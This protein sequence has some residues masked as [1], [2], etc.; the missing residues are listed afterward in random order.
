M[1]VA[2]V[3]FLTH[4]IQTSAVT[5]IA[6]RSTLLA[7]I[8][9]LSALLAYIHYRLNHK[10]S[11]YLLSLGVALLGVFCKPIII[12][13]PFVIILYEVYFLR[14]KAERL[15]IGAIVPYFLIV[16]IVPILLMLL[17]FRTIDVSL[18]AFVTKE[19]DTISRWPYLLTQFNVI[20][21]Y[22]QLLFVPLGQNLDYDFPIARS[23]LEFPT[24]ISFLAIISLLTIGIR[25][26]NRHRLI[27]FGI[28]WFFLTLSLESSIFPIADVIFEHRLYL[29][30]VGWVIALS[31]TIIYI[32]RS[33]KTQQSIFIIMIAMC[34][35]F[36]FQRNLLWSDRIAFLEDIAH[37]SP[38]KPRAYLN[39]GR[40]YIEHRQY[41][42]ALQALNTALILNPRYAQ[43]YLNRGVVYEIF[44]QSEQALHDYEEAIKIIPD[45][46]K[47]FYNIGSIYS[48]EQKYDEAIKYF[49]KA[50]ELRPDLVES[51]NARGSMYGIKGQHDLAL[52]DF[53]RALV[54]DPQN[55]AALNNLA[56]TYRIMELKK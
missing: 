3:L 48:K 47:S 43:A 19:T 25:L 1:T 27:S 45:Y 37:K 4:P 13:L 42:L 23:F 14:S 32:F 38:R 6:Q 24:W 56:N 30:I 39:L 33:S 49:S 9:Y 12:T 55:K 54:I 2:A 51:Y 20:V 8:C 34:S 15:K 50:I 17:K 16:L 22:I 41:D 44:N 46:E 26:F 31:V 7:S 11:F 28:F 52:E 29:P 53:N 10:I 35:M 40:A 21:K 5:Y 18:L 36:T